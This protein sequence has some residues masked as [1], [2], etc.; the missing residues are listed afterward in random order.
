MLKRITMVLVIC[1]A[2]FGCGTL[3]PQQYKQ[4]LAIAAT[5][6]ADPAKMTPPQV[7]ATQAIADNEAAYQRGIEYGKSINAVGAVVPPPYNW[8]VG[9]IGTGVAAAYAYRKRSQLDQVTAA[10]GLVVD[11]IE[12][13]KTVGVLDVNK[14]ITPATQTAPASTIGDLLNVVQKE[15]GKALV[16][17]HQS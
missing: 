7:A 10:S 4:D 3:S 2:M 16:D 11:S 12:A 6:P 13:L 1:G 8:I 14:V 15:A 5:A 9:L 17:Y